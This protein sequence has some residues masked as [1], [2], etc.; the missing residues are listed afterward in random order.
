MHTRTHTLC[1]QPT[2]FLLKSY[3][4]LGESITERFIALE[5]RAVA[6]IA[7]ITA[8]AIH[9]ISLF[10]FYAVDFYLFCNAFASRFHC[11]A[12]LVGGRVDV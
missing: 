2:P 3:L 4:L 6:T 11:T 5:C 8:A 1:K 12:G 10:F 7:S 9:V